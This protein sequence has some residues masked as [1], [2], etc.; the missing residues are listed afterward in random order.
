MHRLTAILAAC[1]LL[2][3]ISVSLG[4]AADAAPRSTAAP[5]QAPQVDT[6]D[7][8]MSATPDGPR[9][10]GFMSDTT[11]VYA[12]VA[13]G[14]AANERFQVR[15]RDLSGVLVK[16]QRVGPVNGT[17]TVPVA[18]KVT[19]FVNAYRTA[20]NSQ[21]SVLNEKLDE[22][23]E[24]CRPENVP[25]VPSWWPT[26][27]PPP[28]PQPGGPTAT[29]SRPDPYMLW[30]QATLESVEI[31][32][33]ATAAITRTLQSTLT[34][35]DVDALPPARD[36]FTA[37][38]TDLVQADGL[39][40][41]VPALLRPVEA[42]QRPDPQAGCAQV[43]SAKVAAD[44]GLA[45]N[46]T[47]WAA[48]P[49]DTSDWTFPATSARYGSN[50]RDFLGC[51]QY[52]TDVYGY[53]GDRPQDTAS[54]SAFW[55]VGNPGPAALMFPDADQADRSNVGTIDV[56][57]PA[58]HSAIYA[59]SV[60]VAGTNHE[61]S[62][63]A[64]VTDR[65]CNPVDNVKLSFTLNPPNA[66]TVSPAEVTIVQGGPQTAVKLEAGTDAVNDGSITATVPGTGQPLATGR[67]S[68]QVIGPADRLQIIVN[69][70]TIA[71]SG[72][73]GTSVV[74]RDKNGR[75]VA[76][77]TTVRL[78][79]ADG[80][81]GQ[82]AYDQEVLV[83]G[84]VE[85]RQVVL[86]KAA[87]LVTMSGYSQVPASEDPAVRNLNLYVLGDRAGKLTLSAEADG[88]TANTNNPATGE[89]TI[90][91]VAAAARDVLLPLLLRKFDTVNLPRP[92]R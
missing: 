26:P 86:G 39:L 91:I 63:S 27:P 10:R 5:R 87:N 67:G 15:L 80:D 82:L 2:V 68:F 66:A 62:L 20:I 29:P 38:R 47:A 32:R 59:R 79:V 57:L 17:G 74:V 75:N 23:V 92:G 48:I 88:K 31:A 6:I 54:K 49:A 25:P 8:Y 37:A 58:G 1:A 16:D 34:L 45:A 51:V 77:G 52:N 72:R 46:A 60:T 43:E 4:W 84:Q 81:P 85:K 40:K 24:A 30:V 89:K 44:R 19:D 90:E 76:D 33:T 21:S 12:V 61:A 41:T 11:T 73:A 53:I 78:R 50:G 70:K 71:L 14:N 65:M 7:M 64:F 9:Q 56:T 28:T 83:G 35:P 36:G 3:A 42:G 18:V 55:T 13:Y 69:P 22:A